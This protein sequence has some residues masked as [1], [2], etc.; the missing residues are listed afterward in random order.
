MPEAQRK[1]FAKEAVRDIMKTL[2]RTGRVCKTWR[3]L[4]K[5]SLHNTSP[6][7]KIPT[8]VGDVSHTDTKLRQVVLNR[9]VL[10]DGANLLLLWGSRDKRESPRK[11]RLTDISQICHPIRSFQRYENWVIQH[12]AGSRERQVT[13]EKR[14]P[15]SAIMFVGDTE[16]DCSWVVCMSK[17]VVVAEAQKCGARNH[18]GY[19]SIYMDMAELRQQPRA[20]CMRC[21]VWQ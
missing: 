4:L 2:W 21:G 11:F 14:P 8:S 1:K 17:S 7:P 10:Q 9:H 6:P 3:S 13:V 12:W 16:C 18:E 5:T 19:R 15:E 20:S